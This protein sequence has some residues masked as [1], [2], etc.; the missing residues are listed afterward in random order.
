MRNF[1]ELPFGNGHDHVF[2]GKSH[3]KNAKK[4]WWLIGLAATMVMVEIVGST[5]FASLSLVADGMHMSTRVWMDQ[6]AEIVGA[7][8]V[9][10]W[11]YGLIRDFL[12][13]NLVVH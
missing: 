10:N 8:V 13:G 5:L 11:F 1:H 4:T 9:A 7:L 2:L 12:S 3:D 6:L